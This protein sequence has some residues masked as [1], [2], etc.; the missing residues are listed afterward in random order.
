MVFTHQ[1]RKPRGIDKGDEGENGLD[2][3][4]ISCE[5]ESF[6]CLI[7]C[8]FMTSQPQSPCCPPLLPR[9]KSIP[10]GTARKR[11]RSLAGGDGY[12]LFSELP[13]GIRP[14]LPAS[15]GTAP[16]ASPTSRPSRSATR[17]LFP[18]RA[19]G[20]R[21]LVP[22]RLARRSGAGDNGELVGTL[23]VGQRTR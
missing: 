11:V 18:R 13:L 22:R 10:A 9:P 2:E 5:F 6:F 1:A 15:P 21:P 8:Y 12:H 16:H 19:P 7:V 4:E 14:N 17:F 20:S 3:I 23:S